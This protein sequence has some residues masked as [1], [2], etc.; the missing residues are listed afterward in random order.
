M[1]YC[2]HAEALTPLVIAG[3]DNKKPD[4][5]AEGLR[6]PSLRGAM[7][8]WFRAMMGGIVGAHDNYKTLRDL[9]G[10][11]FGTTDQGSSIQ[12]RTYLLKGV[13]DTAYLCMNDRR[14]KRSGAPK[15]YVKI[16]KSSIAP[17]GQFFIQLVGRNGTEITL[18]LCSLWLTALLGGIGS[19]SRRGFGSLALSPEND[20]TAKAIKDLG[21][22]FSYPNES[23]D[24]IKTNLE[25]ALQKAHGCFTRYA[26][27]IS[28]P[29]SARFF[30]LT[31]RTAKLFLI[32]PKG[33]FWGR[34]DEAMNDLRCD[35]YRVFK[36][37]LKS[38]GFPEFPG[39]QRRLASPLMIQIKRV[40]QDKY[41]GLLLTGQYANPH[42]DIEKIYFGKGFAELEDLLAWLAGYDYQEVTLP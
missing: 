24:R 16:Q 15:D 8:W 27:V 32:K 10:T 40:A 21:L 9:E 6:P 18:A 3:A 36:G 4:V 37:K 26:P 20:G 33:R 29:P 1:I 35:V 12:L 14:S 42:I 5:L 23:L 22:D 17:T 39:D 30:S 34:W 19:R 28:S 2:F 38:I 41:F 25:S 13:K 7:R 31:T 11:I